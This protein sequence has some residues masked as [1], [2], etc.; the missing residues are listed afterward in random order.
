MF[1]VVKEINSKDNS[2]SSNQYKEAA[3]E[4]IEAG[5]R[6]IERMKLQIEREKIAADNYN[7]AAERNVQREQMK[8]DL[9]IARTN[10]NKYDKK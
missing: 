9:K 2:D 4:R 8:N 5:R 6:D 10:R 1:R 7:Q 3:A